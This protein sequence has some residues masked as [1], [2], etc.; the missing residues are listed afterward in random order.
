MKISIDQ[1]IETEGPD[2]LAEITMQEPLAIQHLLLKEAI[3]R[4]RYQIFKRSKIFLLLYAR[5]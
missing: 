5:E 1:K 2:F 3:R 4:L